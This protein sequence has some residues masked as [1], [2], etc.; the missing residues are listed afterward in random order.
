MEQKTA[1]ILEDLIEDDHVEFLLERYTKRQLAEQIIMYHN[2]IVF[3]RLK[4]HEG[5]N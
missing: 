5:A 1:E 2:D 4:K 3:Q